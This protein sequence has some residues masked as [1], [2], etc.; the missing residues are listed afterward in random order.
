MSSSN[1][2]NTTS[3]SSH[4]LVVGKESIQVI[5]QKIGNN[6]SPDIFPSLAADVEYR[7]R[8][9]M[10]EAIKCMHHS[11][12]TLLTSHDVD[13]ALHLRN[14]EPIYGF[15]SG[16]ALKFKKATTHKDLFYID[17][18]Q[19]DFKNV[20]NAP[21]SKTPRD[22]SVTAQWLAI[23]GV[24]PATPE[25]TL[26]EALASPSDNKKAEYKDDE[27]SADVKYPVKHALSRELQLY[28]EKIT[29]LTVGRSD[30]ILFKEAL[31]S[32][33]TDSGLHPLVPYF[34]YFI[35][36]EVMRNSKSFH[37][38]FAL[39]RLV[40][41]LLRNP[42]LHIEPYLHQ[43]MPSIMTCLIGKTL[44]HKLSDNHWELR[45][46]AATLVS[47]ICKRYG[48]AYHILQPRVTRTLLHTFL[49]STKTL[50]QH[51][52]AIRALADIG[53]SVVGFV[54][55]PNLE[56]YL[57]LIEPEMQ[58]EKQ[59]NETKRYEASRV[60]GVLLHAVG[61]CVYKKLKLIPSPL[62][63]PTIVPWK[64]N[65][66]IMTTM[67]SKRKASM[68]NIMQQPPLKRVAT[69]GSMGVSSFPVNIQRT[70]GGYSTGL[71][72]SDVGLSSSMSRQIPTENALGINGRKD[73]R[74]KKPSSASTQAW[75]EVMDAGQ[76]LPLLT[77]CF[78]E[79]ML[80]FIP[81]PL[82]NI[83]L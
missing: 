10:Q 43:L 44:S 82:S 49:D 42:H 69:E 11:N 38:L 80:T 47:S 14:L 74:A 15:G 62:S 77:E 50:A 27:I 63:S 20:I 21:I 57:Q 45:N 53:P 61:Q 81:T 64:V 75:K 8:E 18:K 35:S 58:V 51:Y 17:D 29:E 25:A 56:P 41:S 66:K 12:R 83:F 16:D 76:S 5:A 68:D 1:V 33:A 71:G 52:G 40:R 7:L 2:N 28:F 36:D 39:M 9:I 13:F 34:T 6:L 70:A 4:S 3:S 73:D 26:F 48:H 78:G 60:Y 23:E 32:L 55:L 30:S 79:S 22:T 31:L 72:G 54:V 24:Q 19:V 65:S 59:K 67:A 46:Y 37:L